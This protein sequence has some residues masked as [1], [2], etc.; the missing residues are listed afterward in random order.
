MHEEDGFVEC[1]TAADNHLYYLGGLPCREQRRAGG[2][3]G[4]AGGNT[5]NH[6]DYSGRGRGVSHHVTA[7]GGAGPYP[8]IVLLHSFN[9]LEPGYLTLVDRFAARGYVVIAP[10]WR[11]FNKSPSDEVV[12]SLI[13]SGV[14]FLKARPDVDTTKLG[15]T[16][17]CAGGRHTMLFLPQMKYFKAGVAWYGFPYN[18]GFANETRPVDHLDAL[19][20]PMLMIHGS[21]DQV[22]PV[23]DIYRYAV[24][25][26][27]SQK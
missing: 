25:L 9:G 14:A 13:S 20:A 16:G 3:P 4:N 19:S 1:G 5:G 8:G 24:A 27:Q 10:Q 15:L 12:G 23:T 22:N 6:G 7:P 21:A 2:T 26:D 11:T 18:P 17:F